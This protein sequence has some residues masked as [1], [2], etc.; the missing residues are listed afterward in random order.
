MDI[1]RDSQVMDALLLTRSGSHSHMMNWEFTPFGVELCGER[2]CRKAK[3][4][5]L[6][7]VGE[8]IYAIMR[9]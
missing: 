4:C 8:E 3:R 7:S 9:P 6:I 5:R 1:A 2:A